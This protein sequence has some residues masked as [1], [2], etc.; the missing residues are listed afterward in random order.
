MNV[1]R[2]FCAIWVCIVLMLAATSSLCAA[3]PLTG[4]LGDL[5]RLRE[6]RSARVLPIRYPAPLA[7]AALAAG[8][9]QAGSR[10]RDAPSPL[11]LRA[12]QTGASID[13]QQ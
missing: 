3:D 13:V 11:Y 2:R 10:T 12:P 5:S 4:S 7:I 6:G 9:W 1:I 8:R